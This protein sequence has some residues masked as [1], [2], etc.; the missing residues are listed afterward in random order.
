MKL[1]PK[2]LLDAHSV[3]SVD[4]LSE[5]NGRINQARLFDLP[6]G[7]LIAPPI[8]LPGS[9]LWGL[10]VTPDGKH[11]IIAD[12]GSQPGFHIIDLEKLHPKDPFANLNDDELIRYAEL[13]VAAA[14]EKGS[15]TRIED[16]EWFK[17]WQATKNEK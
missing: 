7:K 1:C 11:A 10:A 9:S 8:E 4:Q 16:Q 15:P 13:T 2:Y 5:V 17:L 3:L 12:F 6:S 14:L